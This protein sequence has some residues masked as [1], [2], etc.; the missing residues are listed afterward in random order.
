MYSEERRNLEN[1]RKSVEQRTG[2]KTEVHSLTRNNGNKLY[3]I[4]I[5]MDDFALSP[6]IHMEESFTGYRGDWLESALQGIFTIYRKFR[7]LEGVGCGSI[8]TKDCLQL[9]LM[10]YEKNRKLLKNMP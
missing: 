9:R 3:E 2:K 1:L 6:V 7:K 4:M 8:Q 10:N 5:G